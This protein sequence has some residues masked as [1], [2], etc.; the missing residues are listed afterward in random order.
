[1]AAEPVV[2]GGREGKRSNQRRSGSPWS[3]W[4]RMRRFTFEG[5]AIV[6]A[7][8]RIADPTGAKPPRLDH[9]E[10]WRRFQAA[11]DRAEVVILGRRSHEAAPDPRGRK[12]LVLSR[13]VAGLERRDD[14]WWWNPSGVELMEALGS[15]APGGGIAAIPG[16]RE[17]FDLFIDVG[18]DAFYLTRN[19]RVRLPGGVPVFTDCARV[20]SAHAVLRRAGLVLAHRE[21]LDRAEGVVQTIFRRPRVTAV[22]EDRS[23]ARSG[24]QRQHPQRTSAAVHDLQ[25][26]GDDQ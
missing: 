5:H 26:S 21:D 1:M 17:V 25:R 24:R 10:D 6:S 19:T 11:L 3:I 9:P 15:V 23:G 16:G 13:T 12:R 22:D 8:D 20:G 2:T 4:R 18:F 7:D 14:A